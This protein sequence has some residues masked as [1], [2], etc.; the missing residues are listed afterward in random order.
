MKCVLTQQ[1]YNCDYMCYTCFAYCSFVHAL[2]FLKGFMVSS[3]QLYMRESLLVLSLIC[4]PNDLSLSDCNITYDNKIS[5]CSR[6]VDFHCEGKQSVFLAFLV[7]HGKLSANPTQFHVTMV[8]YAQLA[9][10]K[11][12]L[13]GEWKFALA[14]CGAL[15]A[16]KHGIM[17]MPVLSADS[18]DSLLMVGHLF[19]C[20]FLP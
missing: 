9:P 10:G 8:L 20:L 17:T 13:M 3:S 15:F 2:D 16:M 19:S 12:L 4:G 14:M 18:L 11:E 6:F 5:P 1:L 7:V